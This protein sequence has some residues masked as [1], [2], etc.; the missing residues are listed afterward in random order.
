M[1]FTDFWGLFPVGSTAF[2]QPAA[3][4]NVRA[5]AGT[6]HTIIYTLP[7]GTQVN[8][9]ASRRSCGVYTWVSMSWNDG[10]NSGA[11]FVALEFLGETNPNPATPGAA[12][13]T[14]PVVEQQPTIYHVSSAI[15]GPLLYG[16]ASNME[17]IVRVDYG[18][19]NIW[20]APDI[21]FYA[22]TPEAAERLRAAE[23]AWPMVMGA[24]ATV[25]F[26][27]AYGHNLSGAINAMP[28]T[29][30][31]IRGID[32]NSLPAGWTKTN[33]NGFIHI[34]DAS[35]QMRM[36]I[37]P[38]PSSHIHLYNAA[39]NPINIHGTVVDYRSPAAHI[40]IP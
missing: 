38:T 26:A 23:N 28:S 36:R 30:T 21:R 10:E 22:M 27:N 37:D 13:A 11:G 8:I 24:V 12:T 2:V 6:N 19:P 31:A 40:Q 34:R 32:P 33:N 1:R 4:L 14:A 17:G 7:Q 18:A 16:S 29:P 25:S 9:G 15:I 3:G 5:N 39:G 20:T 35:G